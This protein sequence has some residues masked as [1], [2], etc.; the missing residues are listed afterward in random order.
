MERGL[1]G[2][3]IRLHGLKGGGGWRMEGVVFFFHARLKG[4]LP[5]RE[6]G[7]GEE[8]KKILKWRR[9]RKRKKEGLTSPLPPSIHPRSY[10]PHPPQCNLH[11]K[12]VNVAERETKTDFFSSGKRN[13]K[14]GKSRCEKKWGKRHGSS[15]ISSSCLQGPSLRLRLRQ[16]KGEEKKAYFSPRK[17]ASPPPRVSPEGPLLLPPHP[18]KGKKPLAPL[19]LPFFESGSINLSSF[20]LRFFP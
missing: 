9:R 12:P 18:K 16:K 11:T 19:L 20:S 15:G 14:K 3:R 7:R 17:H 1:R 10:S 13:R 5:K 4:S 2:N 6:G 8:K